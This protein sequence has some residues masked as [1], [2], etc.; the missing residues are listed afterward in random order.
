M[1]KKIGIFSSSRSDVASLIPII[2]SNDFFKIKLFICGTHLEK[3]F[4]KTKYLFD[5]FKNIKVIQFKTTDKRLDEIGTL[6]SSSNTI[7]KISNIF[8]ISKLNGLIIVGDRYEALMAAYSAFIQNI[9]VFHLGG[10]ETTLGSFDDKFRNCISIFSTLHFIT[11]PEYKNKL[12]SLGINKKFIFF[13]GD[14]SQ[15]HLLK[16]KKK[17]STKDIEKKFNV[18]LNEKNILLNYHPLTNNLKKSYQEFQNI[19]LSLQRLDNKIYNIFITSPNSD[20]GSSKII[21]QIKKIVRKKIFFYIKNLGSYY[22]SFLQK[23]IFLIGNSSEE[24]Q[25]RYF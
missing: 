8:K 18:N 10:G 21:K 13:S 20:M 1:K 7:K 6:N 2:K 24:L 11:R 22:Y 17:F 19:L 23:C 15:E 9:P 5:K 25:T 14:S 16:E 4:G 3:K 12:I